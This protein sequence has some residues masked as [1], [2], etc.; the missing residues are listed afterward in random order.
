MKKVKLIQILLIAILL[1]AVVLLT[2]EIFGQLRPMFLKIFV[3][4]AWAALLGS[5][6]CSMVLF[7]MRKKAQ[8]EAK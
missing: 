1:V 6:I 8:K 7:F 2:G 4:S 5:G 3:V